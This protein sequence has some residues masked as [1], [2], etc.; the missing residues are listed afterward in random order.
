MLVHR[1]FQLTRKQKM[2]AKNKYRLRRIWS[3]MKARCFNPKCK[4]Y[5]IYGGAGVRL[6]DEWMDF[7]VFKEWALSHGY[8]DNLTIDRR[9]N[10]GDYEP[11]NCR[12]ATTKEQN[13]NKKKRRGS[14]G[15]KYIGVHRFRSGWHSQIGINGKTYSVGVFSD[16]EEAA[17]ARDKMAVKLHGE[18]ATLN[19]AKEVKSNG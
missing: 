1:R 8:S 19:F 13:F 16:E 9:D 2:V 14:Y 3:D 12:W 15:S 10:A 5:D 7:D 11:G 17:R 4:K 6:C 18:F